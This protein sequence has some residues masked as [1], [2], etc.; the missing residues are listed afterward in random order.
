[1]TTIMEYWYLLA[2]GILLGF[3]LGAAAYRF[4]MLPRK[5]QVTKIRMWMLYAVTEAERQLGSGTGLLKLQQVYNGFEKRFPKAAKVVSFDIFVRWVDEALVE[6]RQVLD[7]KETVCQQKK[8]AI[9][10]K[11]KENEVTQ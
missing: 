11:G 6:M 8:E 10:I 9:Q 5:K 1:M 3:I 7:E 4:M 2:A